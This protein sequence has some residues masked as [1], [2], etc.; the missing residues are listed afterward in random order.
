M[1]NNN[2][3]KGRKYITNTWN[4]FGPCIA[5]PYFKGFPMMSRSTAVS[6]DICFCFEII[7]LHAFTLY[8]WKRF[9]TAI[10]LRG[11]ADWG[12]VTFGRFSRLGCT[13]DCTPTG[14]D[15][16]IVFCIPTSTSVPVC[17]SFTLLTS[18]GLG[19]SV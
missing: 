14:R 12:S 8:A 10:V 4:A 16:V 2:T 11:R 6:A 3:R 17:D 5:E 18:G 7:R 13:F 19:T 9:G 1:R 15:G